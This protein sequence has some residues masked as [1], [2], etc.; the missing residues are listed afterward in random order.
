MTERLAKDQGLANGATIGV[1][2]HW[3]A[4]KGETLFMAQIP[5][6]WSCEER[7]L[8][9]RKYNAKRFKSISLYF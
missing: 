3:P 8:I 1:F 4:P 6:T 7:H 5:K 9:G 2:E